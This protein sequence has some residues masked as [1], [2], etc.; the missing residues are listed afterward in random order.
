MLADSCI[1]SFY[2]IGFHKTNR[3]LGILK[4]VSTFISGQLP[5]S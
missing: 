3:P 1:L 4:E 5:N 2:E